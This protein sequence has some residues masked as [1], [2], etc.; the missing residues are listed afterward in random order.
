MYATVVWSI[1]SNS[2][3]SAEIKGRVDKA[4][5][6][7]VN[8]PLR[9]NVRITRLRRIADLG[10]LGDRFESIHEDFPTEF[11]YVCVG[12]AGGTPLSPESRPTWD[13]ATV[14]KIIAED[15]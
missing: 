6:T 12:S 7:L 1:D 8:T 5:G 13:A 9:A 2:V 14:A 3:N 4:F 10:T 15:T 11:D